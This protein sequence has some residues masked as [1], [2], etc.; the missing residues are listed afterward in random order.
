MS[1]GRKATPAAL[2]LINGNPGKRP[3]PDAP[4]IAPGIPPCPEHLGE[5]A[6]AEWDRITPDLLTAQLINPLYMAVLAVYC[7]AWGEYVY[8]RQMIKAPAAEGGGY[9]VTTPNGYSVQSQWLAVMNKAFERMMKAAAEMGL[10]P[11]AMAR[12]A[13][14][15]QLPLF[16]DS[17]PMEAMFRLGNGVASKA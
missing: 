5:L 11:S 1:Q 10:T 3:V 4:D 6:R 2:K 9:M 12:V 14:S 15:A 17:D 16:P 13:G 7:D 8:A